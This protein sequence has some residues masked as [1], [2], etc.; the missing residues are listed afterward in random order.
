MAAGVTLTVKQVGADT[1]NNVDLPGTGSQAGHRPAAGRVPAAAERL[2]PDHLPRPRPAR[3][4]T[5]PTSRRSPTPTR[6]SRRSSTCTARPARSRRT[7]EPQ[8]S[9]DK[10]TAFISALLSISSNELTEEQAQ[11]VMNAAKPGSQA[12][13]QVEGGGSIGTTLSPERHLHQRPDRHPGGDGDPDVHL[14]HGGGDGHAD[15]R[16]HPRPDHG[17]GPDRP[18]GAPDRGARHRPHHGD[19][20]R[21]RGRHRLRPVPGH[22]PPSQLREGMELHESIARAVGTAGTAVVF[23]GCTVVVALL[24]LVVAG[25]PLVSSLGYTGAMAVATAVLAAVTLLPALHVAGRPRASTRSRSRSG[26]RHPTT[27]RTRASGAAG[28]AS[29]SAAR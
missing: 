13:M 27:P 16:R 5:R 2:Q 10:K 29:S 21:A 28:P 15:R 6:R 4:P 7:P 12:G 14:R 23:A 25:I 3:S 11:R 18:D 8:I 19:H 24:S 20:D 17:A 26:S 1:D 9:K 22:P